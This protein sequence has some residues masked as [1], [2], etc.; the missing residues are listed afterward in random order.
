MPTARQ[1]ET[2][3]LEIELGI[4]D[5]MLE[6]AEERMS[7]GTLLGILNSMLLGAPALLDVI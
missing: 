3:S 6:G 1:R 4:V 5:G 7:K 2:N